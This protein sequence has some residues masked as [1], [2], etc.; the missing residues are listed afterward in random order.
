MTTLYELPNTLF[1]RVKPL[2][3]AAPFDQPCYDSVFE[4]VQAAR[5]FVDDA[6]AP[7]SALMFRSYDYFAAGVAAPAL[8]QF[9]RDAPDEAEVFAAFYGCVPLNDDWKAALLADLP[10][11]IDRALQ[12]PVAAGHARARLARAP[13]RR[14]AHR[15]D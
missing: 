15:P 5:I 4:G 3:A 12:F 9:V 13:A 6:D 14:R 10:L 11:E 7:T 2:F 8:R 1:A